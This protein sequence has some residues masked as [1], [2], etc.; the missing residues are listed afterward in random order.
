[1]FSKNQIRSSIVGCG[2]LAALLLATTSCSSSRPEMLTRRME[3]IKARYAKKVKQ[4]EALMARFDK[5]DL[6]MQWY[7]NLRSEQPVN[8]RGPNK[9]TGMTPL[10]TDKY[11]A[12]LQQIKGMSQHISAT[13]VTIPAGSASVQALGAWTPLGPTNQG[14]RTRAVLIHPT[15]PSIMYAAGVDGGVW[16]STDGGG[17]WTAL[18]DLLLP[19]LAVVSLAFE[20]GNYSTIYAGTGEGVFNGDAKRGAG[21]FKSADSGATWNQLASTNVTNFQYVMKIAVSPR[22]VQR[23]Y[24]A[25]R[26]GIFRSIDG[27]GTWTTVVAAGDTNGCTDLALQVNRASGYIFASCGTVFTPAASTVAGIYRALDSNTT[28]FTK[29]FTVSGYGR[30]SLALAPSNENYLYAMVSDNNAGTYQYGLKGVYRS[31][32]NGNAGSFTTQVDNTNAIKLNTLLMTNPVYAYTECVGTFQGFFNQGWYDNILAVDP[33]DPNRVWS[34][35]IDL[36]RSDDGGQNWGVASYWWATPGVDAVYAHADNHGIYFHPGYDGVGNKTMF[37]SSDGGV[38]RTDNAR[39]A[40]G[41]TIN[42]V[43]GTIVPNAVAWVDRN[44]GYAT[45]Q[46]YQGTAYADGSGY[47]G[48]LQDNGTQY[49]TPASTNWTTVQGGD[50]G[51]TAIDDKGTPSKADDSVFAEFTGASITKSTTGPAG[52]YNDATSGINDP[53]F[54]FIAPFEMNSANKQNMWTGGGF[55][56]RTNNQATSWVQASAVTPGAGSVS[57]VASSPIDQN[58]VLIGMSDGYILRNSAAQ[59]ADSTTNW[60]FVQPRT[61]AVTSLAWDPSDAT[62]NTC[63]A[64]YATFSGNSVYK[65]TNAGA[66]WSLIVGVS[67]NNLPAVPAL[68]VVVDPSNPSAIYVGTDLGVFSTQNGGAT[69]SKEVTN[70]AN[71]SAAWL[72]IDGQRRLYA[73]THGRG[74]WRTPLPGLQ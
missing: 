49:G 63:Y 61:V 22:N 35:G 69:W 6:A 57:A 40:V 10:G 70:F 48:G 7:L 43:C 60:A 56:W 34:G 39:A 24:A 23:I 74:A 59:S 1:M 66:T 36:F 3:F 55:I 14:G 9:T 15:T 41:T 13:G 21:I 38:F 30:T 33:A 68:S 28:T 27:G 16:K 29:V 32:S 5:P 18:T 58:K 51:W 62:S 37:V 72:A 17:S 53:F 46:F 54:A 19:N 52:T 26:T 20:P 2:G 50:G 45:S 67:P 11:I 4:K 64:T 73:F 8:T 31:V 47:I 42:N 25:T 65:S 71:V 12:A 44:N